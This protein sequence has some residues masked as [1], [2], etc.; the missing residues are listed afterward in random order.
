MGIASLHPSHALARLRSRTQQSLDSNPSLGTER[1]SPASRPDGGLRLPPS[2][3]ELRRTGRARADKPP[4]ALNRSSQRMSS[5]NRV[6]SS[7]RIP[8]VLMT[9]AGSRTCD[10]PNARSFVAGRILRSKREEAPEPIVPA[11]SD[12]QFGGSR[13]TLGHRKTTSGYLAA[14]QKSVAIGPMRTSRPARRQITCRE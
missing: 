5:A 14:P 13:S 4:Y 8:I 3:F 11:P 9:I 10:E 7:M 1:S 2:L 6:S 12:A